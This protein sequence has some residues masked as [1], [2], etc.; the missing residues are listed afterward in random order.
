MVSWAPEMELKDLVRT[1]RLKIVI[2]YNEVRGC[3]AIKRAI[4]TTGFNKKFKN[5][6][7]E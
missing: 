2:D 5:G 7:T 3:R 1:S 4:S 6:H